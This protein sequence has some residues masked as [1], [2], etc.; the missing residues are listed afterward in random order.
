MA[1]E[2]IQIVEEQP[3]LECE[4]PAVEVFGFA[5]Q[6]QIKMTTQPL[7]I[8]FLLESVQI[9]AMLTGSPMLQGSMQCSQNTGGKERMLT[10]KG[11]Q[12]PCKSAV[13]G[14]LLPGVAKDLLRQSKKE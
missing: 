4:H 13:K 5:M 1:D 3:E 11:V 10:V 9:P 2:P 14:V 8:L 12:L 7:S 6:E